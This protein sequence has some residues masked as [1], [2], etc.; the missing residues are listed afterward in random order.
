L[1]RVAEELRMKHAALILLALATPLAAKDRA[2]LP[3]FMTGAWSQEAGGRVTEERWNSGPERMFGTS[4]ERSGETVL[5]RETLVID[6]SG[7][8]LVLVAQPES[9]QPV[10]FSLAGQDASSIEFTNAQHDYP[11]R[12]RYW[13]QGRE[14]HASISL[15]DGSRAVSWS[16]QPAGG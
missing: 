11:Q 8:S 15:M 7:E 3:E 2:P 16:Y 10:V 9:A 13:R 5:S 12:I 6:R 4:S 1:R 14:L